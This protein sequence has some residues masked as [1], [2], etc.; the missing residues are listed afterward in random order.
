MTDR[1]RNALKVALNS[2]DVA[3]ILNKLGVRVRE[4]DVEACSLYL[5]VLQL[6][7]RSHQIQEKERSFAQAVCTKEHDDVLLLGNTPAVEGFFLRLKHPIQIKEVGEGKPD[8]PPG[9]F[10]QA[11]L[12]AWQ[13]SKGWTGIWLYLDARKI[14]TEF[15]RQRWNTP[16]TQPKLELQHLNKQITH[17][18]VRCSNGWADLPLKLAAAT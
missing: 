10:V 16:G 4:M 17:V 12:N 13:N 1:Q 2:P 8:P 9:G 6:K 3:V 18:C 11:F 15:A 14:T 7:S 5:N